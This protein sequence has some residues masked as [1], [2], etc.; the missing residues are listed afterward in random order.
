MA[1]TL[2]NLIPDVY[3]AL[4]VVSREMVGMIPGVTRDAQAD[5]VAIGQTV[6]VDIA[7]ASAAADITPAVTAP[8]T[9]DQVIGSTAIA[10]TKSRGVPFRWNGEQTKGVNNM[11]P[12]SLN[13]QQQQIAQ[14]IRTLTN[15]VETDLC[16]LSSTFSR[17][18]SAHA[19]TPVTP[20]GTAGDFTEASLTAAILKDNGAPSIGNRLVLN[21]T[22]GANL[23]G[24]QS[25]T[26][27][28][29]QD[30]MLRQGVLLDT[31][32]FSITESAQVVS[33][34]KG[35]M[36]SATTNNAGYA[37]GATALTLATAGTGVVSA[38]DVI[39]IAGDTNKY[40]VSSVTFAGANP[41]AGDIINI[42]A[43]GLLVAITT[44]ATAITVVASS[45]Q[46][47]AFAP[48]AIVLASRLP[49]LP[50]GGD[51]A[52]DRMMVTDPRS[53]LT[54]ELAVYRQYRQVHYELSLAWGVKNIK[55]EHTAILLGQ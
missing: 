32:G 45:V 17:A 1:N 7:P 22:A 31:A 2:T 11:G 54:F 47:L 53:G 29:G 19:T 33:K 24:K 6:Y 5:N 16:A 50:D 27:I 55:P 42:G 15:E 41:A 3:T 51:M 14:A 26:D 4:D 37:V 8:N 38:G 23:I 20:F 12:G 10:I 43:P 46:N 34:T 30:S 28:A 49:A 52:D 35:A 36:A 44:A 18:Y 13:I 39:T 48:S 9:G 40:V 25:R 21:T